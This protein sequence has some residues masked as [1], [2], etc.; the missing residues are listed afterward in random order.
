MATTANWGIASLG[1]L[2]L[3][4]PSGATVVERLYLEDMVRE[5]AVIVHARVVSAQS[6][7]D[8]GHRTILTTYTAEAERYQKGFLGTVF[9]F[10]EPGGIVGD[11]GMLAPGA[12]HFRTGEEGVL[13]LGTDG[14]S[15]RFRTGRCSMPR[16]RTHRYC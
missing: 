16:S 10:S 12:P 4:F 1:V 15:G 5:S 6:H 9:Q 2:L 13:F 3:A 7:W 11:V 8:A 14:R